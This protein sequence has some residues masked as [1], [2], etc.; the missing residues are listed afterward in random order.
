MFPARIVVPD[1]RLVETLSLGI[2]PLAPALG[3]ARDRL[4]GE[5]VARGVTPILCAL[6]TAAR[7]SRSALLLRVLFLLAC[8][9]WIA[10]DLLTGS[11][12][13]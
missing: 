4:C 1:F 2:G 8:A 10:H 5:L 9:C 7:W 13:S 3:A 12:R 6:A 11:T